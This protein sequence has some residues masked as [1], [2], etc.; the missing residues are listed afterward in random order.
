[1]NVNFKFSGEICIQ[2]DGLTMDSPLGRIVAYIFPT[3]LEGGPLAQ[4]IEKFSFYWRYTDDAFI[5]LND[6]TDLTLTFGRFNEV[7]TYIKIDMWGRK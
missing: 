5:F 7:H 3:R 6:Y 1:M 4:Q 2:I